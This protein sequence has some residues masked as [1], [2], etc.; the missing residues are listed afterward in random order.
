MWYVLNVGTIRILRGLP[1][2]LDLYSWVLDYVLAGVSLIGGSVVR[3][4]CRR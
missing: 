1:S 2:S 4:V 3:K